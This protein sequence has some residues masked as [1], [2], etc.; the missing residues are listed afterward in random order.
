MLLQE[1]E[2][3]R[4]QQWRKI[5]LQE[6]EFLCLMD[7]TRKLCLLAPRQKETISALIVLCDIIIII[8]SHSI[9]FCSCRINFFWFRLQTCNLNYKVLAKIFF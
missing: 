4:Y 5:I 7:V 9:F 3:L 1:R 2:V 6:I 8:F